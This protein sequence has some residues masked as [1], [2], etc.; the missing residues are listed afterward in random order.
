MPIPEVIDQPYRDGWYCVT[1]GLRLHYRDYPGDS[2]RPPL[3]CLPGL[4]RNAR[5]FAAFAE[6]HSSGFRALALDFRGRALSD[7]DR[8]PHRYNPLTYVGD[9]LQVLDQLDIAKAILVGT[10]LGGIVTMMLAATAPERIAGAIL[11]DVGPELSEAGLDRIRSYVGKEPRFADWDEAARAIA[12][13]NRNV[14]ASFT[15]DDWVEAAHRLCCQDGDAVVVDYD[16]AIAVPF[17]AA[18]TAPPFDMWPLFRAL[19]R[20][21]L[22]VLRGEVSDLVSTEAFERMRAAAPNAQFAVVPGVGHAPMLDEPE[23]LAATD[24]FLAAFDA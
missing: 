14:P 1:D 16:P 18:R 10:S 9:V 11:N 4:T 2:R 8:Q 21:P 7:P 22:L 24:R 23:A 3:L 17:A 15:H 20:H 5:D 12:A 19:A 13:N 6:R